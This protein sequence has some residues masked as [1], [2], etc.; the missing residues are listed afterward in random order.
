MSRWL[1]SVF[2]CLSMIPAPWIPAPC[3]AQE[4][5]L[6]SSSN[7]HQWRG[8]LGTGVALH[9]SPPVEWS[10]E[11]NVRWKTKLPGKGH[12][13]PVLAKDQLLVTAAIPIGPKLPARFSGRPGEHDNAL[14]D[15]RFQFVVMGID[16]RD[17]K[18]LWKTVVREEVPLEAGHVTGSLANASPVTDGEFVY[19]H[20][21]AHGVYCLNLQGDVVW[22]RSFGPLHSK[23]GHGEGASPT[24][25]GDSLVVNWDHEEGSFLVVMDKR[26]GENRW[27]KDRP[28]DTSWSS[29][30]VIQRAD[31]DGKKHPEIVVCGTDRVCG[32]KLDDGELVWECRGMSSNVV[33]TPVYANGMLYVGS[34]YEKKVLIAI[35]LEGAVGDIT[36][37]QHVIWTRNRSTPYVPSM[38]LYGDAL[39]FLTHYQNVMTRVDGPTGQ[40]QPGTIRLG[41]LGNIYAS[42]VAANGYVYVTDLSG[43]TV[44]LSHEPNPKIVAVNRLDE[45]I[46]ASAAIEGDELFLRGDTHLY[47]IGKL[48]E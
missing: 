2:V 34:S 20:F 21:G 42:P 35:N 36:D 47:C 13:S 1:F 41:D 4:R 37:T 44:V 7:W 12:S 10:A 18:I 25:F 17:G 9:A 30:I 38:L 22:E 23:H 24:L 31:R 43:T 15:S 32:Y 5:S 6:E 46:S 8:P 26:T 40:N 29:P 14:I 39:Y 45:S 19:A 16:R 27:R 11:T 48:D 33:G 3:Q 28:E